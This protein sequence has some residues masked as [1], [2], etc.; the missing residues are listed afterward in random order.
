[1]HA[2]VK[3]ANCPDGRQ[4]GKHKRPA[5][6]PR[7]QVLH[8]G[9]N[10]VAVVS[11]AT[12][13]NGQRNDGGENENQVL[14]RK[15]NR[16]AM[17]ADGTAKEVFPYQNDCKCLHLVHDLGHGRG[18]DTVGQGAHHKHDVDD[19]V[20]GRPRAVRCNGDQ[21]SKHQGKAV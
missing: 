5:L 11:L 16:L 18:Q 8:L 17:A 19:A 9:K 15:L 2:R 20:A 12:T 3:G 7:R 14:S 21:R 1:M 13:A 4:P 10:E 6:R